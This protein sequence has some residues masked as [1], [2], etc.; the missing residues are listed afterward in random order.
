MEELIRQNANTKFFIAS[1][2]SLIVLI[3]VTVYGFRYF[4][5]QWE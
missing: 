1:I 5:K 2:V 3:A 4:F